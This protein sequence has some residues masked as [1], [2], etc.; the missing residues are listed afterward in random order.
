MQTIPI[1]ATNAT[2]TGVEAFSDATLIASNRMAQLKPSITSKV[3]GSIRD[4]LWWY[5]GSFSAVMPL[6]ELNVKPCGAF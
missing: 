5:A 2:S 1:V 4:I 3:I 6:A